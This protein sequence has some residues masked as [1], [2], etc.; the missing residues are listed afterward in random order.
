MGESIEVTLLDEVMDIHLHEVAV[1]YY[2]DRKHLLEEL[3]RTFPENRQEIHAFYREVWGDFEKIR[4]LF[5]QLPALPLRTVSDMIYALKGFR[6]NQITALMKL[7]RRL[8]DTLARHGLNGTMFERF[9]DGI[10]LDSLQTGAKEASHLL[11]AVALSVYH[12][13]AYYVEGG[14]YQLAHA[15]ERAVRAFGD[16]TKLGR[17][18]QS[19]EQVTDGWLITDRRGRLE[20]VDVIVSAIPIERT[21]ELLRGQEQ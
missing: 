18:V 9:I 19:I 16:E 13:G 7:Q 20:L 5:Q 14:L 12:E 2:R 17:N 11:G 6:S 15:L 10:L 4:S 21:S 8:G 1:T 3:S